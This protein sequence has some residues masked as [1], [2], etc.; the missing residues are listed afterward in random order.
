MLLNTTIVLLHRDINVFLQHQ[1]LNDYSII[2]KALCLLAFS[3]CLF[4]ML[5]SAFKDIRFYSR[6][7]D[8]ICL[9][10]SLTWF[11]IQIFYSSIYDDSQM[12]FSMVPITCWLCIWILI[13]GLNLLSGSVGMSLKTISLVHVLKTTSDRLN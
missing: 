12:G 10:E 2:L 4:I 7:A 9:G 6:N 1:L 3:C 8:W 13:H 5:V 11:P